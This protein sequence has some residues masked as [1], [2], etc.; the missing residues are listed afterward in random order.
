MIFSLQT[1]CLRFLL[2]SPLEVHPRP[3]IK[4][5]KIRRHLVFQILFIHFQPSKKKRVYVFEKEK[6]L[7]FTIEGVSHERNIWIW[8]WNPKGYRHYD[9][10]VLIVSNWYCIA[11]AMWELQY[12]RIKD[13]G[14]VC[15]L[16]LLF[17]KIYC[18]NRFWGPFHWSLRFLK[19]IFEDGD[20]RPLFDE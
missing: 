1:W 7:N 8:I 2:T 19:G 17:F 12:R 20:S 16:F 18:N 9:M 11:S 10:I 14:S 15:W 6:V 3:R 5:L 13:L 4:C